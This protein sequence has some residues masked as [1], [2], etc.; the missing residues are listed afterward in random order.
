MDLLKRLR[1]DSKFSDKRESLFI[2]VRKR[3]KMLRLNNNLG[4][5]YDKH[6]SEDGWMYLLYG[7]EDAFGA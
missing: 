3:Q 6:K 4:E 2:F 7:T 5:L 1:Q